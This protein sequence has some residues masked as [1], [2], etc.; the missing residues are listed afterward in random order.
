M[1]SGRVYEGRPNSK[2]G[3]HDSFNDGFGVAFDGS[4]HFKLS[5]TKTQQ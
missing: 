5:L 4:F 3:A 1:P 2:R